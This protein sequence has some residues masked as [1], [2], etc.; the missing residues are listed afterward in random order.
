MSGLSV[1]AKYAVRQLRDAPGFG[2]A[3]VASLVLGMTALSVT[4]SGL[5]AFL[6]RAIP[7]IVDEARLLRVS[8]VAHNVDGHRL[9]VPLSAGDLEHF[10]D[11]LS[12]FSALAAYTT[13]HVVV[14]IGG[15][16]ATVSAE[17]V[18]A[19][20]FAV[21]GSPVR[22]VLD[23][24]GA[25][26]TAVAGHDFAMRNF[27]TADAALGA[28]VRV[29][30]VATRIVAV[31]PPGFAGLEVPELG[32]SRGDRPQLWLALEDRGAH[33]VATREAGLRVVG[34]LAPS[35]TFE[36]ARAQAS[37]APASSN[38]AAPRVT[39]LTNGPNDSP[40]EIA[41]ALALMFAVPGIVLAIGCANAANLLLARA[42]K[43]RTEIAVRLALGA[44]RGRIIRQLLVESLLVAAVA[45][46][47]G[48]AATAVAVRLLEA[49][50]PLPVPMDWRVAVFGLIVTSATGV[51]FGLTPALTATRGDVT[52]VLR[53]AS[54]G[55]IPQ[56]RLR[57]TLVV[58]QIALSLLL[59]VMAG[60]FIRT[61]EHVHDGDDR[62]RLAQ[63]AALTIDTAPAGYSKAEALALRN[64]LVTAAER[65]PGVTSAAAVEAEPFGRSGS[66]AYSPVD[67]SWPGYRP[68]EGGGAIGHFIE[69]AN[70]TVVAGRHF[71][72]QDRRGSPSTA[73]VSESLARRV[74]RDDNP[75]GRRLLVRCNEGA[76]IEVAIVGVTRVV[77]TPR[78]GADPDAIYLPSAVGMRPT[79][80]LW[81]RTTGEPARLVSH[82]RQLV[83][84]LDPRVPVLRS[85][86]AE[87]WNARQLEPLRWIAS[88]LSG[89]GGVALLLAGGGIYAVMT[90]LVASRRHELGVRAALGAAR[91]DLVLLVAREVTGLTALGVGAG[92]LLAVPTAALVRGEFAGVSPFDP[93]TFAFV[94]ALLSVVALL[95][96][97]APA[98]RAM[99]VDPMRVLRRT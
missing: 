49:M 24:R 45:G 92:L 58:A 87:M 31:A 64:A 47:V 20:Y 30:G 60:L 4:F 88:G 21:L 70:L 44:T 39:R 53:D 5:N 48:T 95:A 75:L 54:A 74:W 86:S 78:E 38:G 8:V 29:G 93:M 55:G 52:G 98:R 40:A 10:R 76:P 33:D 28:S 67:Q 22:A 63:V 3:T 96:S 68:A 16:L 25:E 62:R 15:T 84:D 23:P 9:A 18:S 1:D 56:S 32:Q 26:A 59:L 6:F 97:L 91:G 82:L 66:V 90:Y 83:R 42:T 11:T 50:V 71:T 7:G 65:I 61:L 19:N 46:A 13:G 2:A 34:R 14:E 81:V 41:T 37:G 89:L 73:L 17:R 99:L 85:G 57:R 43:R 51:L 36:L 77:D 27:R 12:V 35:G 80:S 94:A 79:F 72:D 69:T